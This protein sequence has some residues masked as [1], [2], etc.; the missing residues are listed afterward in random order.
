MTATWGVPERS[1][2]VNFL[3]HDKDYLAKFP[4][5]LELSMFSDDKSVAALNGTAENKENQPE[6]TQNWLTAR[7]LVVN[8][9]KTAGY[10]GKFFSPQ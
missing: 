2:K 10:R 6:A 5:H 9:N 4:D 3:S 8:F 7:K 1:T